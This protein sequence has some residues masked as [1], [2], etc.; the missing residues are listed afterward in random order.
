[1]RVT[2]HLL[3]RLH[4]LHLISNHVM[5]NNNVPCQRRDKNK[6]EDNIYRKLNTRH[7]VLSIT[8]TRWVKYNNYKIWQINYSKVYCKWVHFMTMYQ[9]LCTSKYKTRCLQLSKG[10]YYKTLTRC[11][12][13]SLSNIMHDND[14]IIAFCVRPQNTNNNLNHHYLH[15][16][17]KHQIEQDNLWPNAQ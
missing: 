4:P 7:C 3:L 5:I 11:C 8:D 9:M 15:R 14:T 12:S 1:M 13:Y 17:Y 2:R 6:A 10:T 16:H